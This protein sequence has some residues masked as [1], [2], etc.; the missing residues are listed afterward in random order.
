MMTYFLCLQVHRCLSIFHVKWGL[1][2]NWLAIAMTWKLCAFLG[3]ILLISIGKFGLL[4]W[5][6]WMSSCSGCMHLNSWWKKTLNPKVTIYVIFRSSN[7]KCY[8]TGDLE[9]GVNIKLIACNKSFCYHAS[10]INIKFVQKMVSELRI[11]VCLTGYNRKIE[12]RKNRSGCDM[13]YWVHNQTPKTLKL[14]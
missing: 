9:I 5:P 3:E 6:L 7:V 1:A 10:Y 14:K 11:L 12:C 2:N 4:L 8:E 13:V